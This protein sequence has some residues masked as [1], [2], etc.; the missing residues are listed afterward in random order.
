MAEPLYRYALALGSNR[1][2]SAR[3]TPAR[4][5]AEATAR[6]GEATRILACAPVVTTPPLGP[7]LRHYANGALTIESPLAPPA[8]LA[9]L[10][11]IEAQLG[12]RRQRRWGARTIDIDII[13]WSGGRW[14]S[15]T[16]TIPHVAWRTRGF[17]LDPVR[18]VAARWRDPVTGRTVRQL[19]ALHKKPRPTRAPK[20]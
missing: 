14:T 6:I 2:R 5:L 19:H 17:V 11:R 3:L 4:L 18:Q 8:M 10:Q 7:S 9:L 1:P 16:L 13:L 15:R 12:R 20:G